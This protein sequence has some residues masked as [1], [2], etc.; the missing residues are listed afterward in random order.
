MPENSVAIASP[1]TRLLA[2]FIDTVYSFMAA[3]FLVI[4]LPS[5]D[6]GAVIVGLLGLAHTLVGLYFWAQGTSPGKRTLGLYVYSSQTGRRLGFWPMLFRET[7]GKWIS[8][9]A[10]GLGYLWLVFDRHRQSWHDKLVS[11]VVLKGTDGL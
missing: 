9:A 11:S 2:Y 7:V 8:G 6:S 10:M 1:A 5:T 3:I 4:I